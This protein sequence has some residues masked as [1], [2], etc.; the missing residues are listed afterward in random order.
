MLLDQWSQM[1]P[2]IVKHGKPLFQYFYDQARP[3]IMKK[4]QDMGLSNDYY[5][6]GENAI[7][8]ISETLGGDEGF[9]P[10]DH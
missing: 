6:K 3:Q 8:K 7:S 10:V 9:N 5:E 2:L 4:L 1:L